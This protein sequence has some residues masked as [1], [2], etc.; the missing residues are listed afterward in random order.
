MIKFAWLNIRSKIILVS[1]ICALVALFSAALFTV[2]FDYQR[3]EAQRIEKLGSI[4][5]LLAEGGAAKVEFTDEQLA[6]QYLTVLD[7]FKIVT[8]ACLFNRDSILI[9]RYQKNEYLPG[10]CSMATKKREEVDGGTLVSVNK[11][12]YLNGNQIGT[13]Q[14]S[15][16]LPKFSETLF[17]S[18]A[19]NIAF[20]ALA[21]VI[22]MLL[23]TR[24]HYLI[25]AP[26]IKL[27]ET[28][29]EIR[30]SQNY[31]I[32][33]EKISDD[34][35]GDL[36][37]AFNDMLRRIESDNKMLLDSEQRF[38][39]LT[40]SSPFGVFQTDEDG[41][42]VYF[43]SRW[44]EITGIS[45]FP[46]TLHVFN[47]AIDEEDR[48]DIQAHWQY[49]IKHAQEFKAEF[50][51]QGERDSVIHVICHAKPIINSEGAVQGFLGSLADVSE[52]KSMQSKLEHLA[53]YD[54]L[55][56]LANRRLFVNR[57]EK[58]IRSSIR[59]HRRF[60]LMFLDFDHFK[61]VN[62]T[63]GHD[64]GDELLVTMAHRLRQCTRSADTVA[65]L[66]G[67]EFTVLVP[68]ID[69]RQEIDHVAR[70]ILTTLK[71]PIQL[72]GQEVTNTCSIGITVFPD[73]G[74]NATALMRN[75]D[76]AMYKAKSSGR[77]EFRYFSHEMNTEIIQQL[78]IENELRRSIDEGE[79]EVYYQPKVDLRN[80]AI[81]GYEA[82]IRW[83]HPYTGVMPPG[84]FIPIAEDSG[85]I[86]HIGKW[87]IRNVCEQLSLFQ[88][89][90]L[91]PPGG[92]VSVNLSARQFHDAQ[93]LQ[94]IKTILTE[95]GAS[96]NSLELEIT[97]SLLMKDINK[98]IETLTHLKAMGVYLS[99]DDFGT[100]Y[101]SFNYLKRL[102]IDII[103]VDRSFVMDIP[104]DR[105]DME[106]AAAIIAM[107]HKLRLKVVAEG[108]ETEEQKA[109]LKG[110]N[111]DFVQGYFFGRPLPLDSL[112]CQ[113]R[114]DTR[115]SLA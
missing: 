29:A 44:L 4:V 79:F 41:D 63:L 111:C 22:G 45:Q 83:N 13:L 51:L 100:G 98:A 34:E 10:N 60:A 61:R 11:A 62:D 110:N 26:I 86:T 48:A 57:L 69:H 46:V 1:T 73:D 93:L 66:G 115:E 70:K 105:D 94:D 7:N 23:A 25:T 87:V 53:L 112:L 91:L 6:T 81:I 50:R 35:I 106:I 14:L 21:G 9:G 49:A 64:Q 104:E 3:E 8:R 113:I 20:S 24:L 103:K 33:A 75:A 88:S 82:L 43:N 36:V 47:E 38:R 17:K 89:T 72:L 90:G 27:R 80:D 18:L 42:Y 12:V 28:V 102:P 114:G 5:N 58:T 99:I 55:T 32:R 78:K 15:S 30:N 109:F 54:P 31:S 95:T 108:V 52:L 37:D 65:R 2:L 59:D 39:T 56:Q 101:S 16:K 76:L 85:L 97:E 96:A 84:T 67:D 71:Q 74:D 77:D 92:R 19:M 107:A 40:A 68:E